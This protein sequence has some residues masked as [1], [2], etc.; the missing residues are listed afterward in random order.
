MA[1]DTRPQK[2]DVIHYA[3]DTLN[4]RIL[5]DASVTDGM[6]WNADLKQ[7]KDSPT[8]DA[9]FTILPPDVSGGPAYLQLDSATTRALAMGQPVTMINPTSAEARAG[10][11][12]RAVQQYSGIWDCQVSDNGSDPVRTLVQ[13]TLI[14]EM[15]VTQP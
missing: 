15:D 1:L 4:I 9:S 3:G 6:T 14:I 10:V 8:V 11:A 13:G 12:P 5:A 2:V 7:A